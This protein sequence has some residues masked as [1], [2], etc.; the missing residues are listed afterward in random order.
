MTLKNWMMEA[1]TE[2]KNGKGLMQLSLETY[3]TEKLGLTLL[4]AKLIRQGYEEEFQFTTTNGTNEY[5]FEN[6]Y[7]EPKEFAPYQQVLVLKEIRGKEGVLPTDHMIWLTNNNENDKFLHTPLA[8]LLS[9]TQ[10]DQELGYIVAYLSNALKEFNGYHYEEEESNDLNSFVI[11]L[12]DAI[13]LRKGFSNTI[14]CD[15]YKEQLSSIQIVFKERERTELNAELDVFIQFAQAYLAKNITL[16]GH[17][18]SAFYQFLNE[19]HLRSKINTNALL[20]PNNSGPTLLFLPF[21]IN[22]NDL[23]SY[24]Q[25]QIKIQYQ[26][27]K[28]SFLVETDYLCRTFVTE[29]ASLGELKKEVEELIQLVK[30]TI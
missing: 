8:E 10:N 28:K 17:D 13:K 29:Y 6:Q 30:D 18:V 11:N 4:E 7:Y 19:V 16:D 24:H 14:Q 22:T 2:N 9:G 26:H 25:V 5:I 27:D 3:L 12:N 20:S 23:F 1:K 15:F 21:V